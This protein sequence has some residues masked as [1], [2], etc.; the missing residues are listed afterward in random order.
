MLT[1]AGRQAVA[2][3]AAAMLATRQMSAALG[4]PVRVAV[5]TGSG[6]AGSGGPLPVANVVGRCLGYPRLTAG[7]GAAGDDPFQAIVSRQLALGD[8]ADALT[9]IPSASLA[10]VQAQAR[11]V[12]AGDFTGFCERI[13]V[14][15]GDGVRIP[16]YAAGDPTAPP[17]LLSAPCG[18]PARLVEPWIRHLARRTRVVTWESRG[19]FPAGATFDGAAFDGATFDGAAFDGDTGVRAQVDDAIAVVET[20]GLNDVHVAGLCGG[21]V[22][23]TELAVA[24]PER[25]LSVSLWHGDFDLGDG[26]A[27]TA[28]QRNLLGLMVMAAKSPRSAASIHPVVCQSLLGTVPEE[29]AAQLLYPYVTPGLLFRYCQLNSAIMR[30]DITP[31]LPGVKQPALVVTSTS[32]STAH[33]GGSVEVARRLPDAELIVRDH[34]DHISLFG[35]EPGLVSL[36][37]RFLG[38][39]DEARQNC[40]IT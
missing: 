8:L 27:K 16:A 19:L 17:V 24:I 22:V 31:T 30:H 12:A 4:A 33:P 7:D 10:Q 1:L 40:P 38:C 25:V 5:D 3:L 37:D 15:S 18:M 2:D 34:G 14:T 6:G 28:H 9:S 29:L 11:R 32:D 35:A 21:A 36:L 13:M 23:A 20:L 39:Q 26:S